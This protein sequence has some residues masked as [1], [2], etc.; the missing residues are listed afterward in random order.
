MTDEGS[1][2]AHLRVRGSKQSMSHPTAG[3]ACKGDSGL[4]AGRRAKSYY[5]RLPPDLL[6]RRVATTPSGGG[7][8]V[9]FSF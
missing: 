4:L 1:V 5:W 7:K 9:E 6:R 8:R 2:Q 3:L